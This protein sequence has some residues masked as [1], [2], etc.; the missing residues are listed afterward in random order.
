M[1]ENFNLSENLNQSKQKERYY[2]TQLNGQHKFSYSDRK[3][4]RVFEFFS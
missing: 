1:L 4:R 2:N 3:E